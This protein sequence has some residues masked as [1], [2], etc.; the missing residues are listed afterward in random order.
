M[1]F[2]NKRNIYGNEYN[3]CALCEYQQ[4]VKLIKK[5][6]NIV[7]KAVEKSKVENTWSYEGICFCSKGKI[8]K[9]IQVM[10]K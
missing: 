3:A 9:L 5:I 1:S 8:G 2:I 6:I 10:L 7:E 4:E